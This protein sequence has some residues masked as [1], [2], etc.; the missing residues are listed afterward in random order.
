M[1]LTAGNKLGRYEIRSKI[2]EGGMGE[3]YQ[4]EDTQLHRRIALKVEVSTNVPS[5]PKV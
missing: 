3:V 1:T 5:T 2:G 4:A